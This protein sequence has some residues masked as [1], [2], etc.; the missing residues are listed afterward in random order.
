M[1]HIKVLVCGLIIELQLA[2][3]LYGLTNR[4]PIN[5]SVAWTTINIATFHR[6]LCVSLCLKSAAVGRQNM[7]TVSKRSSSEL[8]G[9]SLTQ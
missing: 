3:M 5:T 8:T 6:T 4:S 9:K 7:L 2:I 1:F